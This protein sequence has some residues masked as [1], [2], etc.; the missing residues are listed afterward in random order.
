ML[1]D[2]TARNSRDRSGG[3]GWGWR[4][5]A[6]LKERTAMKVKQANRQALQPP[7]RKKPAHQ[8]AAPHASPVLK[9]VWLVLRC[10]R[11]PLPWK[12][13][14]RKVTH[15]LRDQWRRTE[16]Q[17]ASLHVCGQIGKCWCLLLLLFQVT[18]ILQGSPYQTSCT[19]RSFP[20]RLAADI[21]VSLPD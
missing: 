10:I 11:K 13:S 9:I 19:H 14:E 1:T 4:E 5:T 20:I 18:E 8:N 7:P 12:R 2:L 3:W 15:L 16:P 6:V 21:E 17:G